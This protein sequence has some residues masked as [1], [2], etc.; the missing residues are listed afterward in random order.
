MSILLDIDV[1]VGPHEACHRIG[2]SDKNKSKNTIIR[3][4][5]HRYAKKALI[6]GKNLMALI[7]QNMILM[8]GLRFLLRI[9]LL[10]TYQL[11]TTAEN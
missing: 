10:Q 9:Y 1:T 3:H 8:V 6:I 11:P 5:N 7:M 4:V 2:L